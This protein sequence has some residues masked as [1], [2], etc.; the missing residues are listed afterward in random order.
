MTQAFRIKHVP[1]QCHKVTGRDSFPDFEADPSQ[2]SLGTLKGSYPLYIAP[3]PLRPK[4]VP[5]KHSPG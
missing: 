3:C 1:S 4:I 5:N 2:N